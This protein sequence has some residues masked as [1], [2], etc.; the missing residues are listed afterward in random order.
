MAHNTCKFFELYRSC[1]VCPWECGCNR[2]EG[3]TGKCRC[4]PEPVVND[5]MPHFGE[6]GCLV[7]ERG[8]GAI[9]FSYC[10]LSCIFCQTANISQKGEGIPVSTDKLSDIMLWLQNEGCHNINLI[11]PTHVS[12]SIACAVEKARSKGL[13][14]PVVY[15][16]GGYDR[17][18]T[19][20]K[21]EGIVDIYLPD[22]KFWKNETAEKLCGASNYP[23]KARE[24]IKEMHRQVGDLE[25]EQG[26]GLA[27]RGLLVRHLVLPG[28][29]DETEKIL[30]FIA[31]EIS[32]NTYVNVMGHYHPCGKA[33]SIP[34]IN[35]TLTRSEF[36]AAI[37][38]ARKAGLKRLDTTHWHL[39]D[40]LLEA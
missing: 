11:T 25:I 32:P 27:K 30:K 15:N 26:A 4:G 24:A 2:I 1:R 23:E 17:V 35:R 12:P 34:G 29:L 36:N 22:F 21:L 13:N 14:L 39:L 5:Y 19:L 10:N 31:E 20:K 40:A 16:S 38:M 8:S 3:E 7:G 33:R 18:E 6:E 9:F 28:Y 37:E